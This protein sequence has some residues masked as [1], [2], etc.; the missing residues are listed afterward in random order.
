ML[1][2]TWNL[3][4]FHRGSKDSRE[5]AAAKAE[6]QEAEEAV[7]TAGKEVGRNFQRVSVCE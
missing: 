2:L 3:A 4:K 6:K 5:V 7:E 1:I